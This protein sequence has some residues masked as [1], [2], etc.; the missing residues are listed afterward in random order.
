RGLS[1][2]VSPLPLRTR[3]RASAAVARLP[4]D[5]FSIRPTN[6]TDLKHVPR[7]PAAFSPEHGPRPPTEGAH[8]GPPLVPP[9]P[10]QHRHQQLRYVRLVPEP[11]DRQRPVGAQ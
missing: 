10:G 7:E 8:E 3:E 1:I 4:W 6:R 5:V 2:E 9:A 11:H